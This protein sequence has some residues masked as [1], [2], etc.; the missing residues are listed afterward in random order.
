MS[1]PATH[2]ARSSEATCPRLSNC[3]LVIAGSEGSSPGRRVV[4]LMDFAGPDIP[5]SAAMGKRRFGSVCRNSKHSVTSHSNGD[6]AS[7]A[8]RG[9]KWM[10][11]TA[12]SRGCIKIPDASTLRLARGLCPANHGEHQSSTIANSAVGTKPAAAP[13]PRN[14]RIA[15]SPRSPMSRVI[16]LTYIPTNSSA[17]PRS[18]PRPKVSA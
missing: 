16:S 3:S 7:H 18:M 1:R 10:R 2:A 8:P 15:A 14:S 9:R 17:V 6:T 13:R 5:R 4:V 12:A 11:A